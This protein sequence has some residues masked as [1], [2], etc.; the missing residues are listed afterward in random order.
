MQ[1]VDNAHLPPSDFAERA[2]P[3]TLHGIIVYNAGRVRGKF[4]CATVFMSSCEEDGMVVVTEHG[5]LN[6]CCH[7]ESLSGRVCALATSSAPRFL[8]FF[9]PR[10]VTAPP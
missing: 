3:P 6:A 9:L 4:L 2:D 7:G 1:I 5:T 8:F 10:A